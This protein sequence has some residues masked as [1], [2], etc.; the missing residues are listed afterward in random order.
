[1]NSFYKRLIK[2][3]SVAGKPPTEQELFEKALDEV[4]SEATTDELRI[5]SGSRKYGLKV[6]EEKQQEMIKLF[7]QRAE[8]KLAKNKG[9]NQK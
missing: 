4:I 1:M 5:V 9:D 8:N 3:E 2:I 6:K 7:K